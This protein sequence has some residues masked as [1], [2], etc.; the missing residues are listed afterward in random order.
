MK[1]LVFAGTKNGR[2]LVESLVNSEFE[3][4]VSSMSEHGNNLLPNSDNLRKVYGKKS[5]KE[6]IALINDKVDIVID[7]THP[8]AKEVSENIKLACENTNTK[9]I[10][11]ERKSSIPKYVGKHFENMY[12]VC[13]YLSHKEG[14]ILFTTGVN[15][16][17]NIVKDIAIDR[18]H[19]RI[20]P[21][22][23]SIDK[24]KSCSL[25]MDKVITM[26][27]PF[28]IEDNLE[29]IKKYSIKYL[30]TKD[31]GDEGNTN[32]KVHAVNK[33]D[34]E[35]LVIDRPFISY[36]IIYYDKEELIEYLEGSY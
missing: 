2:E 10:R 3:L 30:I 16:V 11:Y 24:A 7:S 5:V 9:L 4:L 27:P 21:V 32:E 26:N 33:T 13:K 19:V 29:H 31:S 18:I 15:E 25:D 35:L 20:I 6:I 36:K 34:I 12:E 8:Y 14:N 28:S 22:K 23:S 17:N 1:I